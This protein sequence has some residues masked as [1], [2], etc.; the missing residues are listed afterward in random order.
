M[1]RLNV[2]GA[3]RILVPAFF[4]GMAVTSFTGNESMA[5][6]V[7]GI[8]A[9]TIWGFDRARGTSVRQCTVPDH[10]HERDVDTDH[11]DVATIASSPREVP[12]DP[13]LIRPTTDPLPTKG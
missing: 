6:V 12:V 9:A 8:V 11:P 7:A 5:W 2:C 4:V 3:T 13:D 10:T 1:Q